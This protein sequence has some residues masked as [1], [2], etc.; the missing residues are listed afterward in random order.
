MAYWVELSK[1]FGCS[2]C[3]KVIAYICTHVHACTVSF[4][5][6]ILAHV[7]VQRSL[8]I[9]SLPRGL[10]CFSAFFFFFAAAE[11]A[12]GCHSS[13]GSDWPQPTAR[14]PALPAGLCNITQGSHGSCAAYKYRVAALGWWAARCQT[15]PSSAQCLLHYRMLFS[16]KGGT[17]EEPERKYSWKYG[18]LVDW[19]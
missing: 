4:T 8:L 10:L 12:A 9:P 3:W 11:R 15:A 5:C 19:F 2:A 16:S 13:L 18:F 7:N 17:G 14:M 1:S 6:I